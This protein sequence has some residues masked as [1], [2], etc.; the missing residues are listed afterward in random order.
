[1]AKKE[2]FVEEEAVVLA[3]KYFGEKAHLTDVEKYL[4]LGNGYFVYPRVNGY[5]ISHH[6][7]K[8]VAKAKNLGE[9]EKVFQEI[10]CGKEPTSPE[11][12]KAKETTSV[13][14]TVATAKKSYNKSGKKPT[15]KQHELAD[16][17]KIAN[18]DDYDSYFAYYVIKLAS[19]ND[20]KRIN[21]KHKDENYCANKLREMGVKFVTDK[22]EAKV[23]SKAEIDEEKLTK[24]V[25]AAVKN[26]FVALQTD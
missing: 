19:P 5:S 6:H 8:I 3:Q 2:N 23:A 15:A 24:I 16:K 11:P 4:N 17:L 26:I 10:G 9:L 25:T 18:I 14:S 20:S 12:K 7:K 21:A 22:P 13:K 1:M